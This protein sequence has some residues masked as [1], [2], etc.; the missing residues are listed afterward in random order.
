MRY[1]QLQQIA[2]DL[3]SVVVDPDWRKEASCKGYD[4]N[5]FYLKN[6][7]E[8]IS[9]EIIKLCYGCPVRMCCLKEAIESQDSF[10]VRGGLT[11]KQQRVVFSKYRVLKRSIST[12]QVSLGMV[13][14]ENT[15]VNRRYYMA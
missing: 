1:E 2:I 5:L 13:K 4:I 14:S 6:K 8:Q 7:Q 9:P 15:Q 10:G 12:S 3:N 11:E